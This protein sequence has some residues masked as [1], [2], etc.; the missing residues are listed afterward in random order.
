MPDVLL[1][2]PAPG[3]TTL[4][5]AAPERRNALT[6]EF[7]DRI[8]DA[9]DAIDADD[10]VGAVVVQAEGPTFC[11]GAHRDALAQVAQDPASEES[12]HAL[13][14]IYAAFTRVG[15]LLPPTV[16]AVRGAAVG[17]GLNLALATDLRVV[18]DD[19]RLTPGFLPL[20]VHPGGGH[21]HLLARTAGR[22]VAAGIGLFGRTV[23]GA[24][25][26]ALGLAWR[27]VPADEVEPLALELSE[28]AGRDPVLSRRMAHSFRLQ[29]GSGLMSW[30]A[31][32]QAEH[33][34]QMWSLRRASLAG[35]A[36]KP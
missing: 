8:V 27:S 23:T 13:T 10:S 18:A 20:G 1:G 22:E 6:P 17:A 32:V 28:T 12:Y 33:S 11:A 34:V 36:R 14:R 26:P 3:V 31:A 5:L 24:E 16:A 35:K 9:C 30:D 29:A 2:R 19:A 4:T 25:C 15:K 21:F 7:A